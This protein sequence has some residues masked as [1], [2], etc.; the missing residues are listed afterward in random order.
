M[1]R[2]K[3]LISAVLLVITGACFTVEKQGLTDWQNPVTWTVG[4][5]AGGGGLWLHA[6]EGSERAYGV[7]LPRRARQ[8]Q[9]QSIPAG[10]VKTASPP[11]A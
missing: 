4:T 2:Y 3:F 8:S 6:V 11:S 10:D 9:A 5:G 7:D 1:R